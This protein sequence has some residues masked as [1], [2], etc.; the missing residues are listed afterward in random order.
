MKASPAHTS[1]NAETKPVLFSMKGG[2]LS[3]S[4]PA[5]VELIKE[6]LDKGVPFRFRAKGFSMSPFIKEGDVIT[7]SP[8]GDSLPRFGDVGVFVN[9][10]TER[11]VVHRV[12]GI[13]RE[14]YLVK[15]DNIRNACELIPKANLLGCVA[16]VE[17]NGKHV[18]L[19][20]GPERYL[21]S[22]LSRIGVLSLLLSHLARIIRPFVKRSA[23]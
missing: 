10:G 2:E 11:L 5:L 4:G 18:S 1:Y 20:F 17:G 16:K 6:V 3:L 15:G 12:V 7:V 23:Q 9:S 21:I 8:L 19:G 13:K 22:L 14:Y